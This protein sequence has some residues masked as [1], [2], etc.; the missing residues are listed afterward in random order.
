[1]AGLLQLSNLFELGFSKNDQTDTKFIQSRNKNYIG[2]TGLG[3]A[4]C[5]E[6][7]SKKT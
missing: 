6:I 1:M 3:L 2:N 7:I 4:F 5:Q